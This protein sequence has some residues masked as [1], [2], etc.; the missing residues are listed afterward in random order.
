MNSKTNVSFNALNDIRDHVYLISVGGAYL[1]EEPFLVKIGIFIDS[2]LDEVKENIASLKKQFPGKFASE[3]NTDDIIETLRD[4]SRR[5]REPD[6][7]TYEKCTVGELGRELEET[8]KTL[9]RAIKTIRGQVE[10]ATPAYTKT[11]SALSLFRRLGSVGSLVPLMVKCV[12]PLLIA[13]AFA[14]AFLFATMEKEG[15]FLEEIARGEEVIRLQQK[16]LSE[17]ALEKESLSSEIEGIRSTDMSRQDKITVLELSV[18]AQDLD[19]KIGNLREDIRSHETR[20]QAGRRRI[21]EMNT[22]PFLKR[23]LRR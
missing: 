14:F 19:K 15:T 23:L 21:E 2:R 9:T 11:D 10:G 22:K 3:V 12:V 6:K 16:K 7:K 18:K 5:L 4:Q 13:A 20:I 17:L 1:C 8:V